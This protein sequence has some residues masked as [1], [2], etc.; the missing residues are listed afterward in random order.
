[1]RTFLKV[2]SWT[3]GVLLIIFLVCRFVLFPIKSSAHLLKYVPEDASMVVQTDTKA[4][5]NLAFSEFLRDPGGDSP[6]SFDDDEDEEE[7]D[8]KLSTVQIIRKAYWHGLTLPDQLI[9]WSPKRGGLAVA[10]PVEDEEGVRAFFETEADDMPLF[11]R[12]GD[13][14]IDSLTH[15]TLADDVLIVS[16]YDSPRTAEL[17]SNNAQQS[18]WPS[19]LE[20]PVKV[21]WPDGGSSKLQS[22]KGQLIVS[23]QL[24]EA[25]KLISLGAST[26]SAA[27]FDLAIGLKSK[28]SYAVLF[29]GQLGEALKKNDLSPDLVDSL[30]TG[31]LHLEIDGL[32][33][34]TIETVTYVYNDDFEKVEKKSSTDLME[35]DFK[36]GLGLRA[37]LDSLL[38]K[39]SW[40]KEVDGE[41][42]FVLYPLQKVY[43]HEAHQWLILSSSSTD[44]AAFTSH[45]SPQFLDAHLEQ[46][47]FNLESDSVPELSHTFGIQSISGRSVSEDEV[48]MTV[49]FR[50]ANREGLFSLLESAAALNSFLIGD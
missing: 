2:L 36:L 29:G 9:M 5:I 23:W 7:E 6:L 39:K 28:P 30:W 8:E 38:H 37:P 16:Q 1:M 25:T 33:S 20:G 47:M 41:E 43:A 22:K 27:G 44:T 50:D 14:W 12:D 15:W 49:S 31:D 21:R 19:K 32:R 45:D 10:L 17:V 34:E 40:V 13:T 46:S 11:E 35:A 18:Q 26:N 4:L 24:G 42:R 3:I 48:Q